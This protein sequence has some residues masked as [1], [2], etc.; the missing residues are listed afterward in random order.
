MSTLRRFVVKSFNE[1]RSER[2][3]LAICEW[4]EINVKNG[5]EYTVSYSIS[6]PEYGAIVTVRL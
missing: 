3:A 6:S 1:D 5:E 4:L 2:L